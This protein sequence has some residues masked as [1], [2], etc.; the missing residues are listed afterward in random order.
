MIEEFITTGKISVYNNDQYKTEGII[1]D[2][3]YKIK[4]NT[5]FKNLNNCKIYKNNKWENIPH[6]CGIRFDIKSVLLHKDILFYNKGQTIGCWLSYDKKYFAC[7]MDSIHE[8][9]KY[10][11]IVNE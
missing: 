7:G 3:I 2:K 9:K 10:G 6:N 1:K 4:F 8:V 11:R 5:S